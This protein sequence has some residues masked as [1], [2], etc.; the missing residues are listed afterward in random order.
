MKSVSI[1]M[2]ILL[3][4][5]GLNNANAQEQNKMC[6][7]HIIASNTDQQGHIMIYPLSFEP[8]DNW[9][10]FMEK[11]KQTFCKQLPPGKYKIKISWLNHRKLDTTITFNPDQQTIE[12]T[13]KLVENH[14]SFE[15]DL[16]NGQLKLFLNTGTTPIIFDDKTLRKVKKKLGVTIFG[17]GGCIVMSRTNYEGIYNQEVVTFLDKKYG[18]KWRGFLK[19]YI[20]EGY[21]P[22]TSM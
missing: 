5:F 6:C 8:D 15:D 13:L 3:Y 2:I 1:V 18:E 22:Q 4:M 7:I 14:L 10:P 11:N 9:H 21:I 17:G 19:K 16:E 12:M 20:P